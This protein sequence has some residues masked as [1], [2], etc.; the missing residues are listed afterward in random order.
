MT[1]KQAMARAWWRTVARRYAVHPEWGAVNY[2]DIEPLEES[3]RRWAR[4]KAAE[5]RE[6]AS[7]LPSVVGGDWRGVVAKTSTERRLLARAAA[8]DRLARSIEPAE[9]EKLPF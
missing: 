3:L 7:S 6:C 9:D 5:L 1:R 8:L 4:R 2:L